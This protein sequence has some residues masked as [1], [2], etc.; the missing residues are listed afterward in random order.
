MLYT[1]PKGQIVMKFVCFTLQYIFLDIRVSLIFADFQN[2]ILKTLRGCLQ[3]NIKKHK[4]IFPENK[5]VIL[6]KS[7]KISHNIVK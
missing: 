2:D 5:K 4:F 3:K 6:Q 1:V 7:F